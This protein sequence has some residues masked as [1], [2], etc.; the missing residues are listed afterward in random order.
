MILKHEYTQQLL[1]VSGEN[2]KAYMKLID[3][4]LRTPWY[5][6]RERFTTDGLVPL[7]RTLMHIT[8]KDIIWQHCQYQDDMT[9]NIIEKWLYVFKAIVSKYI[10]RQVKKEM[11]SYKVDICFIDISYSNTI[12][13]HSMDCSNAMLWNQLSIQSGFRNWTCYEFLNGNC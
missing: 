7:H 8:I 3:K 2:V 10:L 4:K 13:E 9:L 1:V 5:K 12:E 6:L 11:P